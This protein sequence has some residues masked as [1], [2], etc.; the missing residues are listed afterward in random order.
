MAFEYHVIDAPVRHLAAVRFHAAADEMAGRLGDALG[1]VIDVLVSHDIVPEGPAIA[2]FDA[3]DD[4]YDVAVGYEVAG[5]FASEGGIEHVELPGGE[6][7]T[8]VHVGPSESLGE[9]ETELEVN[10][11]ADGRELELEGPV[12]EEYLDEKD[13]ATGESLTRLFR[14][15]KPA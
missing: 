12:W 3:T 8:T 4:G 11:M 2:C 7:A 6:V 14:P 9:T 1:T 10:I 15:L 5:P 13:A